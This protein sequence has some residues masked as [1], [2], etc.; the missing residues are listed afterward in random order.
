MEIIGEKVRIEK[1]S[2]GEYEFHFDKYFSEG[3]DVFRKSPGQ[4]ILYTVIVLGISLGLGLIPILGG[5][6]GLII[7]PA[8]SAG[9]Y[10]GIRKLDTTNTLEIGDFFKSFDNLL[11]L[12]LF[13]LVSGLLVILGM[14]LLVLPGIWLSIAISFGYPLIVLAKL[15]FWDAIKNSAK[16]VSKK[17]FHFFGMLILLALINMLGVLFLGLG[18]LITIP[19]TYGVLYT[20][21]KDIIGFGGEEVHDVTDHLIDDQI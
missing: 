9:F 10:V 19:F 2:E 8:L 1:L 21:Y 12:F 17:W 13:A 18:L 20:C 6:A 14:I 5:I 11:Q 7:G 16:I 3:W 4:L 15:E